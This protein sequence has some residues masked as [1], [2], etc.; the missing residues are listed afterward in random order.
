MSLN[1]YKNLELSPV[2]L[3]GNQYQQSLLLTYWT[4]HNFTLDQLYQYVLTMLPRLDART[5]YPEW[6][7]KKL[8][9]NHSACQECLYNFSEHCLYFYC[10]RN[11][12]M[13][14]PSKKP[15]CEMGSFCPLQSDEAHAKTFN[16]LIQMF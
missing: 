6:A 4:Q 5:V 2:S 1:E 11:K 12:H 7:T 16:H 13:I 15:D 8:D 10:V 9:P 14:D 3:N